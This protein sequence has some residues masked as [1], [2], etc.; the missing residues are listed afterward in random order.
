M[1]ITELIMIFKR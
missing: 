1:L